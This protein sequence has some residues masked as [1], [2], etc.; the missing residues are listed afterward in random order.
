MCAMSRVLP[1]GQRCQVCVR[2][3]RDRAESRLGIVASVAAT[4]DS[5]GRPRSGLAISLG[6][7]DVAARGTWTDGGSSGVGSPPGA[8]PE[9]PQTKR[10]SADPT[11]TL[12][13]RA[14]TGRAPLALTPSGGA[15]AP[16]S[17]G[18]V[19]NPDD[20]PDQDN[21]VSSAAIATENGAGRA[22]TKP[23][24]PEGE[25]DRR[26][27]RSGRRA[28]L[29]VPDAWRELVVSDRKSTRLNSSHLGISYAV[30]CL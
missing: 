9:V 15:S 23:H 1:P 19:D 8:L 13:C 28:Q 20:D 12:S 26:P 22:D 14:E 30:L 24:R 29:A 5:Q 10:L 16:P 11:T 3:C 6:A 7:P 18:D 25:N 4:S 21:Y 27:G 17:V 2:P